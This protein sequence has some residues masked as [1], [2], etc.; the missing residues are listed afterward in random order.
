MRILSFLLIFFILCAECAESPAAKNPPLLQ[1]AHR[2]TVCLNMIVKN[3]KEVICRCLESAKPL[4]DYWVIV[5]TGSNDGTQEIIK[6]FMKDVPGELHER[7]WVN[8]SH[9]RNE[10]L[11]L[12]KEKADY[13]LFIDADDKFEIS[14]DFTMPHLDRDGYSITIQYSNLTYDRIQLIKTSADWKW[15]GV[16]HEALISSK[17]ITRGHLDEVH[18][19]IIGG[20]DRSCDPKKFEKDAQIL[21]AALKED[22]SCA[23]NVFYLAQS[24]R[25]AEKP[26]LA[27]KNYERRVAMGGWDQEV[28]WSHYQ[29]ALLHERINSSEDTISKSYMKAFEFRPSRIEPLYRLSNYY[30]RKGNYWMGYLVSQFGLNIK[31]SSDFLFLEKWAYDYGLLL[32]YSICAYWIGRY[33]EAYKASKQ[34]LSQQDLPSNIQD[35]VIK[36]L[37]FILPKISVG[38]QESSMKKAS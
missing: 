36:N 12:A 25:D 2:P 32:E 13:L 22:P 18:M 31:P 35:C 16:L 9:N 3:E 1:K 15:A 4:I 19:V 27:L 23:R 26:D 29:I 14:P 20:G 17:A 8:F 21:E 34:I 30:R 33:E 37:S 24:Y 11:N 5:D 7:P 6:N 38:D 28:F 10:A